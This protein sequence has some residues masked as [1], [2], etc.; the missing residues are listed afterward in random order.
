[1]KNKKLAYRQGDVVIT[2]ESAPNPNTLQVCQDSDAKILA[3]GETT[4]HAHR[5]TRGNVEVFK[6]IGAIPATK[7]LKALTE[8]EIEHEEHPTQKLPPL[9]PDQLYKI[10][11]EKEYNWQEKVL[12]NVAD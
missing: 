11:I 4:G 9:P 2:A 3:Y 7:W 5:V 8:I 1:M 12:R 6:G 10:N